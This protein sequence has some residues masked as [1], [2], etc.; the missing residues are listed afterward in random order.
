MTP[1]ALFEILQQIVHSSVSLSVMIW[2]PPGIGKS[3]IVHSVA[4]QNN[5]ELIDLRLSQLAPT[6]VRGLPAP[7]G[8]RMRWLPPDFLPE[9]GKGILFLDEINMAL[10]AMQSIA[11]QLILDRKVGTY[12]L[13]D[14]WF[15][16]A[17]GNRHRDYAAVYDM[18]APLLNRFIHFEVTPSFDAF[19]TYAI[20]RELHEDI[21]GFLT[22]KP[23]LLHKLSLD[24]PQWPSPRSWEMASTL[25]TAGI[26]IEP[27]VGYQI[28]IEF[29]AYL[30][31]KK[32]LPDVELILSNKGTIEPPKETSLI[33]AIVMS[34]VMRF[35]NE[36]QAYHALSWILN[37][38]HSEWAHLFAK[39][40]FFKLRKKNQMKK[41]NAL[42]IKDE[43]V[44]ALIERF[45][46]ITAS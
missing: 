24:N 8:D 31:Q 23:D 30:Q 19:K 9:G 37:N 12:H 41:F 16:W 17:A 11:Q 43:Q 46:K 35:K 15:I 14:E 10:P 5:L 38:L 45:A 39:D 36:K 42:V 22:L 34:L 33:C 13:P 44:M 25:L 29:T 20:E 1:A 3:S 32:V 21:L 4:K 26:G 40:A 28:A 18:P 2:G 6:D 7:N 27:A